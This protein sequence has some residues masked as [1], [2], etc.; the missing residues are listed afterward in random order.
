MPHRPPTLFGAAVVQACDAALVFVA[1]VLAL[2]DTIAGKSYQAGSGVALTVIGLLTSAALGWAAVG[3]AR[4]RRW[5][6]TPA[7]LTQLFVGIV[8]IY[9]LQ[10]HRYAW[11]VPSLALALAGFAALLAPA[12]LRALAGG[13]P[14]SQRSP[15]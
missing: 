14:S 10:G 9:L 12:S 4:T 6:R 3:L 15:K 11:G 7:L 5:A 8:G 2:I 13:P 1:S